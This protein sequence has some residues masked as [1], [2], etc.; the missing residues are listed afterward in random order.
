MPDNPELTART[1]RI[2]E[3]LEGIKERNPL[4]LAGIQ[5]IR[6]EVVKRV[7]KE[8]DVDPRTVADKCWR[9]LELNNISEFDGD[10]R[11]PVNKIKWMKVSFLHI[12]HLCR[13]RW[14]LKGVFNFI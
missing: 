1:G 2:V 13:I 5:S 9:G 6:S 8:R 11:V 10:D 4:T 7:A 12:N 14:E 3:V